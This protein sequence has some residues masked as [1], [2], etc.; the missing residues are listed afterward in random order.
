MHASEDPKQD[1]ENLRK[2]LSKLAEASIR[3]NESLDF[4]TV[5][6]G[7]LDSACSLTGAQYGVLTL[8]DESG[9]IRDL[10]FSG[11]TEQQGQQFLD[12]PDG[13]RLFEHFSSFLEPLR[14][15]DLL[16]HIKSLGLRDL[17]L[18][19]PVGPEVPFMAT[20]VLHNGERVGIFFLAKIA[21]GDEFS[22]EDEE[23]LMM[24]AAQAALVVS[25]ARRFREEQRARTD[26]HTLIETSPVG[27][28]VFDA[29]TGAP[30]SFNQEARRIVDELMQP[31]QLPEEL[32]NMITVRR[33]DGTEYSLQQF[34]L[35]QL[36]SLGETIRAE[37][38]S[39]R[40][41]EGRSITV[42]LNATPIRSDTGEV[43]SFVITLQDMSPLEELERLRAELLAIVSHEL[44]TPLTSVKGSITTL[45][46]ASA[47][48]N[49]AEVAQFYR[50]ID[51]QADRMRTMISDLLDVARIGM[52]TLSI[53]PEP[54]DIWMLIEDA[55]TAF[56]SGQRR[57]RLEIDV[58]PGI[59]F[60][61]AD[62][63]R[64]VQVLT[65]LLSN[66][67]RHSEESSPIKLA[68]NSEGVQV[69][70]CVADEGRG[71]LPERLPHLFRKFTWADESELAGN[72]STGLGLAICKGIVEAHGGRIWA[73]SDGLGQG[74]RFTFT[75]PMA[76]GSEAPSATVGMVVD[77]FSE[78]STLEQVRVLVVDDDPQ[79]LRHVRETLVRAGCAAIVTGDPLEVIP[80]VEREEPHLVLLDLAL[81]GTD[82]IAL[83]SEIAEVSDIPVI[84]LSAYGREENI[85]RALDLGAADY[86]VK[87]FS[88]MELAARVRA[89]LR[90]RA[91]AESLAPFVLGDLTIDFTNRQVT[92]SGQ[93][94]QLT[95]IEYRT[96]AELAA[97]AGRVL[98][99]EHL[100]S[101]VWNEP[102]GGDIR[103]M[104]TVV[105]RIRQKLGDDPD[106]PTYIFT[107]PRVGY[108]M[109]R[110]G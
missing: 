35:S 30:V 69:V 56:L 23:I 13:R 25:N 15:P 45:L 81:P 103:P 41:P 57:Q 61:M 106:N 110:G 26:L 12:L 17:Q 46:D 66:A 99:Y 34:P 88:S 86:I 63:L 42:L 19:I 7:V 4:D 32:L 28:A 72:E 24:F 89:A 59:P 47:S 83:M 60:V 6:Q 71:V 38:I 54:T 109:A 101:Q 107:E 97:N 33:G 8:M 2:R 44:R 92:L 91:F 11:M 94:V 65:N 5:L 73:E 90:Q 37:E 20:P 1:I 14:V 75:L 87:P 82:G 53:S 48:L 51:T 79:V 3:I 64:I 67:A 55:R 76:G 78:S 9:N 104:R 84:F 50:I 62:R 22:Q 108:R 31:D 36:F 49:P 77:R 10:L 85:S 16:G 29:R 100:L 27:V 98:A 39:M 80:L 21:P 93:P 96:L 74:A 18:P 68:V 52:G 40:V 70:V 102:D 95:A 43:G 105:S 58:S